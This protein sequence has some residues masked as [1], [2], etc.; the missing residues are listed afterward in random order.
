MATS[1]NE[2]NKQLDA[3]LD[4]F[5]S[6]VK[7]LRTGRAS[8]AMLDN[9]NVE[10][11]GQS[12]ALSHIATITV[13]DAQMLQISPFDPNNLDT[14][15]LAIRNDEALGLNPADDGRV[16]RVPIPAMTTERRQEVVKTLSDM[17]EDT[18]ISFR[19]IRHDVLK[20]LKQQVNDKEMSEDEEKRNEDRFGETMDDYNS[21]LEALVKEKEQEIMTV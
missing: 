15:S 4:H 11:Y 3:A 1:I 17:A 18:R 16:V 10:V 5:T 21:K 20:T 13:L 9:V 19:N 12:M 8:A 6:Q 2:A 14:I 7:K